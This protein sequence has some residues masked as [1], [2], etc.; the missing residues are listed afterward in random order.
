MTLGDLLQMLSYGELSNL[1]M[2]N[3]GNGSI[4]AASRPRLELY[5]NEA[6]LRLYSRFVLREAELVVALQENLSLYQLLPRFA[7][8]FVAASPAE[9]ESLRYLLDL[10]SAPFVGDIIKILAV[11]DNCGHKLPL[12]DDGNCHSLFTPHANTLQVPCPKPG[13]TLS[14]AYQAKHP[15]LQGVLEET[16]DVPDILLG[17]LTSYVAYKVFSHMNTEGSTAKAQE[18]LAVYE[19]ICNDAVDKDLINS[20]ISTTN[21]RFCQRGW[22]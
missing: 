7:V 11:F 5:T 19:M 4:A 16:V 3:G 22:V 20:S 1:S 18:Y 17:A 6:L 21:V 13:M 2:A 15:K 10:P 8:N 9:N 14:I 12:N